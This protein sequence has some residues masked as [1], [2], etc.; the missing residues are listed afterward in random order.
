VDK[1]LEAQ[2]LWIAERKVEPHPPPY[3]PYLHLIGHRL[4]S[5]A[6]FNADLT[7]HCE[8]QEDWTMLKE[9]LVKLRESQRRLELEEISV[10][11]PGYPPEPKH[12]GTA[13][14]SGDE[15]AP[16]PKTASSSPSAAS[17]SSSTASASPAA[18][19]TP[20][21][22]KVTLQ[23]LAPEEAVSVI[24]SAELLDSVV[25]GD[26]TYDALMNDD[27]DAYLQGVMPG[28]GGGGTD[29]PL[30]D[31]PDIP[32]DLPDGGGGGDAALSSIDSLLADDLDSNLQDGGGDLSNPVSLDDILNGL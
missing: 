22:T 10:L 17:S 23:P 8:T 24:A 29:D 4:I 7:K 25:E 6:A 2:R 13:F 12:E 3:L 11:P 5:S 32:L 19:S 1:L 18:S 14:S 16:A 9:E 31:L 30:L 28:G 27:L 26:G 21:V 15:D 20:A